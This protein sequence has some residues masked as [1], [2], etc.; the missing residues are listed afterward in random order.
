MKFVHRCVS[1]IAFMELQFVKCKVFTASLLMTQ[2]FRDATLYR[3]VSVFRRL[4]EEWMRLG[5]AGLVSS[6]L[7]KERNA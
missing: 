7:L 4:E 5:V 2:V 3:R 1:M 6:S